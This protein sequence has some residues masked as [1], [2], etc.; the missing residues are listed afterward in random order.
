MQ[1][2]TEPLSDSV[3]HFRILERLGRGGM[4]VVYKAI[5][6]RLERTVALKFLAPDRGASD[7][8]RRRF[9]REARAASALD[10]PNIC[11]LYEIGEAEDGRLFLAMTFCEGETLA[12]RIER[13]PLPLAAAVELAAQVAAGLEAAHEKGIVH[14]DIKPG[15]LIVT[16][17]GR[18]KIVDFGIARRADQTQLTNAGTALGTTVYMSPEQLR[19][20]EVDRRT[21]LWSLGVV[22]YEMVTGE[23]P[24]DGSEAEVVAGILQRAPRPL[25]AL[26][27]GVPEALERIV[28]R[29]LAKP[30]GQR[31]ASAAEL[32]AELAAVVGLLPTEVPGVDMEET[33][34]EF[35]RPGASAPAEEPLEVLPA[36][37]PAGF[38]VAHFRVVAPLGGGGMGVV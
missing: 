18:L 24:F 36:G 21:D 34:I 12:R 23:I 22:L 33:L 31:Y 32:R 29:A 5:D 37:L 6:L 1:S 11:T 28:A 7:E 10:H 17:G 25:G 13:G 9:L 19:G 4:G 15:N 27:P 35:A 3:S 20:E 14:R 16:P 30:R 26:R 2:Q 38:M 8:D